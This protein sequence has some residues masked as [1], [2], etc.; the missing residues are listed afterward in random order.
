MDKPDVVMHPPIA[1]QES[2]AA[3]DYSRIPVGFY[4][5]VL[6][7]GSPIRKAWHAH[8][9]QRILDCLPQG[10]NL[11]ILDIGCFA[12]SFLAMLED[13]KR[14]S[15]QVGV[16]I[17]PE[18]IQYANANYQTPY[19]KFLAIPEIS[20]LQK[21]IETLFDCITLI[22]VI[23]HLP[24]TEIPILIDEVARRLKPGGIF[25]LSTPNYTSLWPVLEFLLTHF[26]DVSYEEQH[27]TK[28]NIF[29]LENRLA[30]LAPKIKTHFRMRFKTTSHLISPFLAPISMKLAQTVSHTIPHNRWRM[31]FGSLCL[32]VFEKI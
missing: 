18:Q 30:T 20:L 31:P 5:Q 13:S 7:D 2:S 19:R 14:F 28:F 26:S 27:I 8:K 15:Y 6:K 10:E 1:S 22:E 24:A 9:F 32:A 4:D 17:L 25:V 11:S 3:F 12:G 23:E 16:D 29:T 21:H